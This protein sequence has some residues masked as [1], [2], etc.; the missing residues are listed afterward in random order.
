M[1]KKRPNGKND[2]ANP[3]L[4]PEI[5][6]SLIGSLEH[7]GML[8]AR[9]A[10]A[11][12]QR[13]QALSAE[14]RR[15]LRL[16]V[17][18]PIGIIYNEK[19]Q[20]YRCNDSTEY[21]IELLSR[22]LNELHSCGFALCEEKDGWLEYGITALGLRVL[23]M[24]SG[25]DIFSLAK[26]AELQAF[27]SEPDIVIRIA[28]LAT[29][30]KSYY[31]NDISS[32]SIRSF[33]GQFEV[34]S[35]AR[36]MLKILEEI[37]FYSKREVT[38]ILRHYL[39]FATN[40]LQDN[41]VIVPFG[42]LAD[43]TAE[44][45]QTVMKDTFDDVDG[46][47]RIKTLQDALADSSRPKIIFIDDIIGSGTQSVQM[48]SEM[49]GIWDQDPDHY[50]SP[51]SEV[52]ISALKEQNLCLVCCHG[53]R[54]GIAK[55]KK[56]AQDNQLKINVFCEQLAPVDIFS[57]DFIPY[58]WSNDHNRNYWKAKFEKL[59]F[60]LLDDGRDDSLRRRD[61]LGWKDM[62]GLTVYSHNVPTTTLTFF[63]KGANTKEVNWK[64]LFPRLEY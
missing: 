56:F 12:W 41:F 46:L 30:F 45:T 55:L 23:Q 18:T 3:I 17:N 62:R 42:N 26:Q 28:S 40:D 33:L 8:E 54:E 57:D 37:R 10:E 34:P 36:R 24:D 39:T 11:E 15:Y 6:R 2:S 38:R 48:F 64:P 51:L 29:K 50:S 9:I 60:K 7:G 19:I 1:E 43:S 32:D 35:D 61:A 53:S 52:E 44:M 49:I 25:G 31:S 47:S 22:G 27:F 13:Y 5:Y 58:L 63:W 4:F 14:A 16:M 59:G 21:D 20:K